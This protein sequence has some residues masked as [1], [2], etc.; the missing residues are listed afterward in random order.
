MF[1]SDNWEDCMREAVWFGQKIPQ[2]RRM[3]ARGAAGLAKDPVIAFFEDN[4]MLSECKNLLSQIA[5]EY[6][7]ASNLQEREWEEEKIRSEWLQKVND[8]LKVSESEELIQILDDGMSLPS[9]LLKRQS[10]NGEQ[11]KVQ[12]IKLQLFKFWPSTDMKQAWR[13]YVQSD[14]SLKDE[15]IN[16]L[17]IL[18]KILAMVSQ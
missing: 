17:M 7:E 8:L 9:T 5:N 14:G 16:A 4:I 10:A 11:P 1:A 18:L 15:N 2:K 6:T 13:S 12:R 3:N